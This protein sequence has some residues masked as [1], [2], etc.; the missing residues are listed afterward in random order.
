VR[1]DSA[2][3]TAYT[4]V[5]W[6]GRRAKNVTRET[7]TGQWQDHGELDWLI[8]SQRIVGRLP[9]SSEMIS[10]WWSGLAGVD[11]DL[12]RERIVL[13][14]VN[15]WTGMLTGPSVAPIA[16]AAIVVCHGV[17]ALLIHPALESIRQSSQDERPP[18][19]EAEGVGARGMI[20]KL[21]VRTPRS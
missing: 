19:P 16:I 7:T 6:L 1:T 2:G 3:W 14:A 10:I 9:A 11:V 5:S 8:T 20:V 17:G 21:P 12:K 15:R 18:S 4:Q 13:N